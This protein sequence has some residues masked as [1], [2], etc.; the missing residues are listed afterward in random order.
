MRT[1]KYW[2]SNDIDKQTKERI[3]NIINGLVDKNISNRTR[4]KSIRLQNIND[5]QFLPLWLAC[6]IVYDRHSESN[7]TKI[8]EK[9]EDIDSYLHEDFKPNS[10]RN[11][12]V[13]TV[14][15]E[16]LKVTKDIWMTYGT[17]DEVHIEM[18][19]DLKQ[20]KEKRIKDMKRNLQ[21]QCELICVSDISCRNSLIQNTILNLFV[22]T[23]LD[24][25]NYLKYTK[26]T[27]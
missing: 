5:F 14:L 15:R 26:I 8:W 4:E 6:Y 9:P 10:L 27:H 24:N 11:P 22:P 3:S 17:I 23:P 12:I 18:G 20:P 19:R 16:A 25:R 1:G 21:N 7:D 13:E 2:N